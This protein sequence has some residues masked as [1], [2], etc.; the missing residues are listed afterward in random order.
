MFREATFSFTLSDNEK[1]Y[2]RNVASLNI[3]VYDVINLLH[4]EHWTDKQKHFTYTRKRRH[5]RR[6]SVVN[7][8]FKHISN[9]FFSRLVFLIVDFEQVNVSWVVLQAE[10]KNTFCL[11]W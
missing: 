10:I 9:L 5:W 8:N 2:S 4:Y 6:S 1:S 3:L 7:V 11:T